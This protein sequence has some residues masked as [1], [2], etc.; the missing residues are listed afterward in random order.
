V[1]VCGVCVCA[2]VCVCVCVCVC[3]VVVCVCVC[4]Y[5]WLMR[6]LMWEMGFNDR[7]ISGGIASCNEALAVDPRCKLPHYVTHC[8][9]LRRFP[10]ALTLKTAVGFLQIG[11]VPVCIVQHR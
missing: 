8:S 1:F 9:K 7:H 2:C 4:V 5:A 6:L 11:K 10:E 3:G